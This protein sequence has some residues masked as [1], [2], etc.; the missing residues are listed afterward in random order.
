MLFSTL[1]KNDQKFGKLPSVEVLKLDL[2]K[3]VQL[4]NSG[5]FRSQEGTTEETD[6]L[7]EIFQRFS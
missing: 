3:K 2:R 1:E 5:I 6:E 7:K 4:L